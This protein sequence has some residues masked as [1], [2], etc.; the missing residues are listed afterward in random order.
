MSSEQIKQLIDRIDKLIGQETSTKDL[1]GVRGYVTAR[2][3]DAHKLAAARKRL[4]DYGLP[5]GR[6]AAFPPEQAILLNE[7]REMR[8]RFDEIAKNVVFT[9]SQCEAIEEKSKA[10]K[11]EPAMLAD[12]FLPA[13]ANVR[14]TIGRLDQ[15]IG[16]L[17]HVEALRMYA[18]EHKGTFPAKLSEVSVPLPND[19]VTDKPFLY[20]ASG[21]TA[22]LRGT[23]P[24]SLEN[25]K[26]FRVHYELTLK[27]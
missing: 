5:E 13:L 19:P 26:F 27:N 23:P 15:R 20:E 7:E 21:T 11:R 4:V 18:A 8:V 12:A 16:L 22:H 14:R 17:R 1:G 24:K 6:V 10:V 9:P 25:D 2:S 3:K